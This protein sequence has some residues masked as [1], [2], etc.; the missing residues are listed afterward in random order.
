M[1]AKTLCLGALMHSEAS[2]YEIRKLFEGGPFSAIYD[3]SFGSIYPALTVL[4][5]REWATCCVAEQS[6]R[7][8]KKVYSITPAGRVAFLE[9]LST[10]PAPDKM[11]SEMLFILSFGDHLP[12]TAV[13][14]LID[15]YIADYEDRLAAIDDCDDDTLP[16]VRRFVHNFGITMYETA[17]EYLRTH[18]ADLVDETT[19]ATDHAHQPGEHIAT[20]GG[21]Q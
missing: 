5:D 1:D 19:P 6:G 14:D 15:R 11:R 20:A 16:P 21:V 7:P 13:L 10:T 3:V 9:A 4:L 12:R 17:L 2:G 18:R 8:D